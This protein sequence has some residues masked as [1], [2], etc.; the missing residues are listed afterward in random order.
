MVAR[1]AVKS[2][3]SVFRSHFGAPAVVLADQFLDLQ[4]TDDV[5]A[6]LSKEDK[7]EKGLKSFL[8]AHYWLF[9]RPKNSDVMSSHLCIPEREC[10]GEPLWRWIKKI[11][12]LKSLKVGW[13]RRVDDFT[14]GG[15]ERFTISVL[16]LRL[17][18]GSDREE[19]S[20]AG[21][22]CCCC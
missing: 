6:R 1:R 15:F 22:C 19:E 2:P 17:A 21:R 8:A 10:R 3:V 14:F 5:E 12:H 4:V 11:H 7:T 9:T 18:D 13:E 16:L 20:A